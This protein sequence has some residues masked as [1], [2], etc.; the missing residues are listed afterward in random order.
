MSSPTIDPRRADKVRSSKSAVNNAQT[1][2]F[3]PDYFNIL[4]MIFS[5]CGLMMKLKWCGKCRSFVSIIRNSFYSTRHETD[6][7]IFRIMFT[8]IQLGLHCIV[9]A[10]VLPTQEQPMMQ[11]R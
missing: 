10:S 5:M 1:E 8:L 6:S 4:G 7:H 3:L 9:H 2:D 11:N